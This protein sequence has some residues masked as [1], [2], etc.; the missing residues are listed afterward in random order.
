MYLHIYAHIN[1]FS[2]HQTDDF[3]LR[4]RR[5]TLCTH[6]RKANAKTAAENCHSHTWLFTTLSLKF[7]FFWQCTQPYDT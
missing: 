3:R 2:A 5:C 7:K 1:G 6:F 4:M